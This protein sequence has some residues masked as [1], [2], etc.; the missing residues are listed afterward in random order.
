[1]TD[2]PSDSRPQS[3]PRIAAAPHPVWQPREPAFWIMSSALLIC[4]PLSIQ[5][6]IVQDPELLLAGLG[7]LVLIIQG[8][9][10]WLLAS[11]TLRARAQPRSLRLAAVSWGFVVAPV[12]A[13]FANSKWFEI[14]S[15][16][17]LHSFAAAIS[18]PV[19]EDLLRFAGILGILAIATRSHH[20]TMRDGICYG[21]LVG[22]GF[23]ISENLL[24]VLGADDLHSGI[25]LAL[26]RTGLGFGLHA[27][28]SGIQGG[29]LVAAL[30]WFRSQPLTG[31]VILATGL[32]LPM[33]LHSAW[34]G[35]SLVLDYRW[36]LALLTTVYLVGIGMLAGLT[37]A[38]TC[39]QMDPLIV[40]RRE[41]RE[42]DPR[43]VVLMRPLRN[44]CSPAKAGGR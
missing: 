3:R 13:A 30:R 11:W 20:P 36:V 32:V 37:I 18:A 12:I 29:L 6:M 8:L 41:L 19:N 22:A 1:M 42:S 39:S 43:C 10:L 33:L 7:A 44:T 26:I 15:G 2:V 31:S 28:W 24:F 27:L 14:L 23:E 35:P 17:G 4:L 16:H 5:T 9:I 38:S 34:D 21:F 25:Q 40:G